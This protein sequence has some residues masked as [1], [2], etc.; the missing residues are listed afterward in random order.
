MEPWYILEPRTKPCGP[1]SGGFILTH[2]RI[3]KRAKLA[4]VSTIG[5]YWAGIEHTP[6]GER[7]TLSHWKIGVDRWRCL[8]NIASGMH[9]TDVFT[10]PA[11][12][13]AVYKSCRCSAGST[14]L[15][16]YTKGQP[17]SWEQN[18]APHPV[19]TPRKLWPFKTAMIP[20]VDS[21]FFLIIL[22]FKSLPF[23]LNFSKEGS[24]K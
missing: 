24:L 13:V 19:S 15:G 12:R 21:P 11:E 1:Y 22:L 2:S 10:S 20:G 14:G 7:C 8:L 5:G 6:V 23:S 4:V 18:L 17:S 9:T 3:S 16:G